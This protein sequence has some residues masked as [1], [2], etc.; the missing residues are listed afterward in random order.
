MRHNYKVEFDLQTNL[1]PKELAECLKWALEKIDDDVG[2]GSLGKKEV[3][4]VDY[5]E[6]SMIIADAPIDESYEGD[7]LSGP[8]LPRGY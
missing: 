6:R 8:A 3:G 4:Y 7:C 1:D 5:V 2:R